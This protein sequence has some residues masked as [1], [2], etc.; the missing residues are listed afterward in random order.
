MTVRVREWRVE[1]QGW[2]VGR[3]ETGVRGRGMVAGKGRDG[4]GVEG[5]VGF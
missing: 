3:L 2:G 4:G 1:A 5:L